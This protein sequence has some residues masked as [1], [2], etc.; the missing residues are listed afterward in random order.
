MILLKGTKGFP[1]GC[2]RESRTRQVRLRCASACAKALADR[3]TWAAMQSVLDPTP[4]RNRPCCRR[5]ISWADSAL[6]KRALGC[7]WMRLLSCEFSSGP[8]A[9]GVPALTH[10]VPFSQLWPELN[11]SLERIS[12]GMQTQLEVLSNCYSVYAQAEEWESAA[13]AARVIVEIL[14]DRPLGF[15]KLAHALHRLKRTQ[16]ALDQLLPIAKEHPK[17][18]VVRYNLAC[19]ACQLR[20]PKEARTW[21]EAAT[22][23]ANSSEMKNMINEDPDLEPLCNEMDEMSAIEAYVNEGGKAA[24][25][26]IPILTQWK[27][28]KERNA[29]QRNA[30]R[31]KKPT[32]SVGATERNGAVS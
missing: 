12:A 3:P 30:K 4:V 16:E 23:L 2:G 26:E 8:A 19:C 6:Q 27:L 10:P 20:Q 15:I 11:E 32:G 18:W 5:G 17:D 7:L 29:K 28:L 9:D 25:K 1:A 22:R 24:D 13:G 31:V 21:L 14:P